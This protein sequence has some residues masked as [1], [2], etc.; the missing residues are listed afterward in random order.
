MN[1]LYKH[2]NSLKSLFSSLSSGS[3]VADL[4]NQVNLDCIDRVLR[5][6][7]S[8][9]DMRQAGSFFTGDELATEAVNGFTSAITPDSAVLDPTCGAGN[10]LIACSRK[11]PIENSLTA[12]LKKW[13]NVLYGYDLYDSFVEATKL[14]IILEAIH[15]GATPDCSLEDAAS[16]LDNIRV[17]DATEITSE[18]LLD[19]THLIMNP[20]FSMWEM[21]DSKNWNAGI[22]NAAAVIFEHYLD[23][24][25]PRCQVSAILPEVLRS[26][27]RYEKLRRYTSDRLTGTVQLKG[28]FNSKTD[29][30][31]FT[32]QG[33]LTGS[34]KSIDWRTSGRT[35]ESVLNDYFEVSVGPLVAY[36]SPEEGELHPYIH[37]KNLPQWEIVEEF[38]EHRRF[39]GRVVTPP[40][41]VIRRTSRPSSKYRALGT[42]I[43]GN[44]PIAVENHLIIIK[45]RSNTLTDCERLTE[46]LMSENT[47]GFLNERI[48]CRHLTVGAVKEI[49]Y[50]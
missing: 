17:T 8:I 44:T 24:L 23:R 33:V 41:V 22:V 35:A 45:P 26:G 13:G 49:P 5:E 27:T 48:R 6:A 46:T 11:L 21:K 2:N 39:T 43:S 25:P 10:L 37:S 3:V 16:L 1:Q 29:V 42:I 36:R 34:N 18:E 20:P 15:R 12:T 50:P 4:R 19:I 38:T 47:N 14:R 7:L 31:V 40:F 9:E 28:Q 32:L 30:D